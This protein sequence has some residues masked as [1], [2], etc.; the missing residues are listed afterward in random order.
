MKSSDRNSIAYKIA[1]ELFLRGLVAEINASAIRRAI[2][3]KL[4]DYLP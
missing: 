2:S 4:E 3:E 1:K